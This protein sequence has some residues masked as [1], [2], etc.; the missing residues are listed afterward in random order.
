MPRLILPRAADQ[1]AG[2]RQGNVIK[3]KYDGDPL[4]SQQQPLGD[5]IV[6]GPPA[7]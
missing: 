3:Y 6:P 4:P 7:P 5:T 2:A 1:R